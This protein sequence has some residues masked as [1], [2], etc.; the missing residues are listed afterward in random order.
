M[1]A[2]ELV[3]PTIFV[4]PLANNVW[5]VAVAVAIDPTLAV[6]VTVLPMV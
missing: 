2:A 3:D 5:L 4:A 1:E 6:F